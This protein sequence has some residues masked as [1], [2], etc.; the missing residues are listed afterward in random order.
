MIKGIVDFGCSYLHV[1]NNT[2]NENEFCDKVKEY[3]EGCGHEVQAITIQYKPNENVI[4][5]EV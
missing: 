1:C 3:I 2:D 5:I 4:Y